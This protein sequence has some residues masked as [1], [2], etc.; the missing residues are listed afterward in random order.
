[1]KT[2][3]FNTFGEALREYRRRSEKTIDYITKQMS[4]KKPYLMDIE[5]NRAS[6]PN[7]EKI[8]KL[9][10]VIGIEDYDYL[11]E[12]AIRDKK[13]LILEIPEDKEPNYYETAALLAREWDNITPDKLIK[14]KTI[15][16]E[17]KNE[18]IRIR[19]CEK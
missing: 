7:N 6:P 16:M 15:L 11:I 10:E 2:Q 18:N 14:I 17:S 12:L 8:K 19:E 1:M 3:S 13:K 5:L 9:C 4:W